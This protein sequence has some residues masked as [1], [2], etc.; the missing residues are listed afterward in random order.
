[1][2]IVVDTART[3]AHLVDENLRKLMPVVEVTDVTDLP[4]VDRDL[5]LIRVRC[6]ARDAGRDR[7]ARRRSSAAGSWTWRPTR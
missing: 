3:P 5:A 6:A 2:T 1:M 7:R 4:T